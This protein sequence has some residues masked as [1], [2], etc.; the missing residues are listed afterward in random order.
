[1]RR[2]LQQGNEH[3]QPGSIFNSDKLCHK[4]DCFLTTSKN[5]YKLRNKTPKYGLI[6]IKVFYNMD[7]S[8]TTCSAMVYHEISYNVPTENS[9]IVESHQMGNLSMQVLDVA[10]PVVVEPI[11]QHPDYWDKQ[12]RVFTFTIIP[13]SS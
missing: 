2:Y 5:D 4:S 11:I 9:W 1:M 7:N 6:R 3:K 12:N 13:S 8:K 10:A